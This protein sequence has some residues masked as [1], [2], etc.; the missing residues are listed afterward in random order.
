MRGFEC[1]CAGRAAD[2]AVQNDNARV[3]VAQVAGL[4]NT[5]RRPCQ[6]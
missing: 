4:P 5:T 2:V 1:G 3:V 6:L